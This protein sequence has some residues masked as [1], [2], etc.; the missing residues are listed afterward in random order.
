MTTEPEA[1]HQGEGNAERIQLPRRSVLKGLGVVAASAS[2]GAVA[3]AVVAEGASADDE[4]LD[5][6][7]DPGGGGGEGGFVEWDA[8]V[9]ALGNA[10]PGD[11]WVAVVD[12]AIVP[13]GTWDIQGAGFRG[14]GASGVGLPP[15]GTP[16]VVRFADGARLVNASRH[17]ARDGIVLRSESSEPVITVDDERSYYFEDDAWVVSTDAAFFE[18]TTTG[19]TL[20]LFSFRTGSGLVHASTAEQEGP[21]R[22]SIDHTGSATL[23]VAMASGNNIFDDDTVDGNAV[24]IAAISSA[25]GIREPSR[26][27]S[28]FRHR[29]ATSVTQLLFSAAENVHVEPARPEHWP[30]APTDVAA[31]LDLLA[32]RISALEG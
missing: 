6:V 17:L 9:H 24:V 3:G 11:K 23:I 13:P 2:A 5:F 31:A 4:P 18:V 19:G 27:R 14:Q 32:A 26:P 22:A 16:T 8:L 7:F 1:D 28:G 20:V 30:D 21:D 12:G 15:N 25:A 10:P 29:G